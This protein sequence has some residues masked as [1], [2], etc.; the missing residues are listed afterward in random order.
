MKKLFACILALLFV[1]TAGSL[2]AQDTATAPK[3]AH[4]RI[5]EVHA[6]MKEQ[7]K[8]IDAGVKSGKLTPDQAKALKDQIKAV[9]AQM[10]ADYQANGKRELTDDQK[11]QLNQMLD[12]SSKMIYGEKHPNAGSDPAASSSNDGSTGSMGASA[13]PATSN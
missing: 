2:V 10:E 11:A 9:Q 1:S 12:Q 6:R 13:A 7:M 8:R 3:P 4:P 5:H